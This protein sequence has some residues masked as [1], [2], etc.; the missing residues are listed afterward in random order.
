MS[1]MK[2]YV[3]EQEQLEKIS[4]QIQQFTSRISL[5]EMPDLKVY[6]L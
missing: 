3:P 2:Q 4:Q 5:P 1:W 6:G